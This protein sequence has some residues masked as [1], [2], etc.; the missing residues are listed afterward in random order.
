MSGTF[1]EYSGKALAVFKLT[2]AILG[3]AIPVLMMTLYFGGLRLSVGGLLMCVCEYL[4]ILLLMIVIKNTNP[5]VRIDQ[6]MRFF[7]GIVTVVA[8]VS[9]VLAYAGL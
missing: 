7:W 1:I 4:L 5:R 3:F 9:A 6:A 2:K 8:A